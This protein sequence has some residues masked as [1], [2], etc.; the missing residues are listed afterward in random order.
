MVA[1]G[2]A[3]LPG[4]WPMYQANARHNGYLPISL[5]PA[6]FSLK[7]Q[8]AVGP[9]WGLNPVTVADGKVFVSI[10]SYFSGGLALWALDAVDGATLW[11][12]DFGSV[13]SVNPPSFA[14]GN[15]YVQTGNHANDTYLWA[16]ESATGAL[17][18]KSPH[19]AQWERYYAPTISDGKVY[20]D[21][22]S[23]GGMYAFD[24]F[25]GEQLWFQN[26]PQYDQWTPAVDGDN[27]Y[28]YVGEYNPGLYVLD[29]RSGSLRYMIADPHFDW[30]GWSMNEAPALGDAGDALAIHDGRLISFDL[31][32]HTLR[33]ERERG[34]AGQ[35]SVA[36]GVI[37]A[38]DGGSLVA[39][40]E[41]SGADLWSW[42]PPEGQL[43]GTLVVT[44]SHILA[45]S[46]ATTYAVE[47]ASRS[48]VWSYP[49]AGYLALGQE[50]LY[51][52]SSTGML[53]AI[54]LPEF[55][56]SPA[57]QLDIV[58]QSQVLEQSTAAYQ[59][60]VH[61]AD[62]RIRE[63]TLT[64]SWSVQPDTFAHIDNGGTLTTQELL[65]PSTQIVIHGSYT[66]RGVT[67][68]RD[69][70][71]T[72]V[73]GVSLDEFVTRN[74]VY[75][76]EAGQQVLDLLS[77]ALAHEEAAKSVLMAPRGHVENDP[78]GVVALAN[79]IQAMQWRRL[80]E[81]SIISSQAEL[82]AAL[83]DILGLRRNP[84]DERKNRFLP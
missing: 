46:F 14:Y 17:V 58:G 39:L 84:I 61:Y 12:K 28:A 36:H 44:D 57:V 50:T 64:T 4:A 27:A 34:F 71:V 45:S 55:I 43:T 73:I 24:A 83:D 77:Q 26:L 29:R 72:L 8:R 3:E 74:L 1:G 53:T 22:G 76:N 9:E 6:T 15:V 33:W 48:Q 19:L 78:G 32:A 79:L 41:A 68:S 7:W 38:I 63:R 11:S 81:Q 80:G 37:Y 23:Y 21:G 5:D 18:F 66:E 60:M 10:Q 42:R 51:V 35:P 20:V 25:S 52:A 16:F 47:I 56:P 62:G 69:F 75:A 31:A 2:S 59:A 40:D 82:Q 67:V 65:A 54:S 13:F 30:D 49:V 70:P